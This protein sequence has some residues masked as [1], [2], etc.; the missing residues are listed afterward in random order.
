MLSGFYRKFGPRKPAMYK[1]E[2]CSNPNPGILT[3]TMANNAL[4]IAPKQP[5]YDELKAQHQ[6]ARIVS[7][8][9]RKLED[10]TTQAMLNVCL[11]QT[12]PPPMH[13]AQAGNRHP[14]RATTSCAGREHVY[15]KM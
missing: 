9:V 13:S 1:I 10:N 12:Y 11:G 6:L 8:V 2:Q 15:R 5:A 4:Q 14:L 7:G 3:Q